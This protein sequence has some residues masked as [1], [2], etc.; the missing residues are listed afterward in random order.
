IDEIILS[1][2]GTDVK[3]MTMLIVDEIENDDKYNW[4]AITAPNL[5]FHYHDVGNAYFLCSQSYELKL[6]KAKVLLN[7]KMMHEKSVDIAMPFEVKQE[8]EKNLNISL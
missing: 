2:I 6:S 4:I 8:I 1:I 3:A 7:N 5:L